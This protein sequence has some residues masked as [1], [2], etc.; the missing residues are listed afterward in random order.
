MELL[1]HCFSSWRHILVYLNISSCAWPT[2]STHTITRM[3]VGRVEEGERGR[4][5]L[6]MLSNVNNSSAM[7]SYRRSIIQ[8][9]K[10]L[11]AHYSWRRLLRWPKPVWSV[12]WGVHL[13]QHWTWPRW[14]YVQACLLAWERN[15]IKARGGYGQLLGALH[16]VC[17]WV[18][19]TH[20]SGCILRPSQ[21]QILLWFTIFPTSGHR[22]LHP[23]NRR[24]PGMLLHAM[25]EWNSNNRQKYISLKFRYGAQNYKL[26]SLQFGYMWGGDGQ[27]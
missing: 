2:T 4:G 16:C 25:F 9:I 7:L 13:H 17:G 21:L 20:F 11:L 18:I 19:S 14:W 8:P 3:L 6:A 15:R 24:Q 12:L 5:N 1:N 10:Q 22:G 27:W 23:G 26:I